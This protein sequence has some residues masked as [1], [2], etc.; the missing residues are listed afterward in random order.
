MVFP[1][2]RPQLTQPDDPSIRHVPLTQGQYTIIDAD[3]QEWALQWPWR[4]QYNPSTGTYYAVR[5]GRRGEPK[6]V[7]LHRQIA[8]DPEGQVVD[9]MDGDTLNN[10]LANL[11]PCTHAQ[12]RANHRLFRN[13]TSGNTGIYRNGNGWQARIGLGRKII[14]LGTFATKEEAVAAR[15]AAEAKYFGEFAFSAR[16]LPPKK[17]P[18]SDDAAYK[19]IHVA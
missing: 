14:N 15:K 7:W 13:N 2:P 6:M 16:S 3:R 18:V 1:K 12:N 5:K 10:R 9:H 19:S 17:Q 8:G 11:R 4:G